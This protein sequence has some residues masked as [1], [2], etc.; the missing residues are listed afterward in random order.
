MVVYLSKLVHNDGAHQWDHFTHANYEHI[1]KC[2]TK[3][4]GSS[5]ISIA[6]DEEIKLLPGCR[7]GLSWSLL[8]PNHHSEENRDVHCCFACAKVVR[9]AI[10]WKS[11]PL[12]LHAFHALIFADAAL[13]RIIS[14][15][16]WWWKILMLKWFSINHSDWSTK[17][18]NRPP[19]SHEILMFVCLQKD[20]EWCY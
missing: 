13:R 12:S 3:L 17:E 6:V 7:S 20:A 4:I 19:K 14:S 11:G 5:T 18:V 15:I 16:N 9:I 10:N 2:W 8:I 1:V